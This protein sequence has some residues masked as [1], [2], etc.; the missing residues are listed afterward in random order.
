[1]TDPVPHPGLALANQTAA[2]ST[3]GI[4]QPC[5]EV[6][7]GCAESAPS[8]WSD[9]SVIDRSPNSTP[10]ALLTLMS[11]FFPPLSCL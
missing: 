11:K 4:L 5:K 9:A 6:G 2:L 1:M 10:T 7:E 8:D 3:L